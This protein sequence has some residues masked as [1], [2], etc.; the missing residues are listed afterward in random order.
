MLDT[1]SVEDKVYSEDKNLV[2]IKGIE[3]PKLK[4]CVFNTNTDEMVAASFMDV[5]TVEYQPETFKSYFNQESQNTL[6]MCYEGPLVIIRFDENGKTHFYNTKRHDCTGSFWGDKEEKFGEIFLKYGGQKFLD[7]V[8]KIPFIAHHFM[9]MTPSL[10]TTSR[11]DFRDN[12]GLVVYLGSVSLDGT[13]LN[14]SEISPETF[15]YHKITGNDFLPNKEEVNERILIPSRLTYEGAVHILENG[16][17]NYQ[18]S[19][20][21]NK[22][23][24]CGECVILRINNRKIIKFVPK[25]HEIRNFIAGTTPNIKNRLYTIL[26]LSKDLERYTELF[27]KAGCLEKECIEAIRQTPCYETTKNVETFLDRFDNYSETRITDRMNNIFLVCL[28]SCPLTKVN[29]YIDAWFSYLT[30]K[31]NVIKFIKEKNAKIRNGNYDECLS[32]FH[33]KALNRI[34]DIAKVSKEYAT[35][36]KNGHTYASKLEYSIKGM[37]RN[38]FGPSLYRIEKALSYL[39]QRQD[40]VSSKME[41]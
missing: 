39:K 3:N 34:K 21:L 41:S 25:C 2:L 6:G 4:G 10:L 15:Y 22:T 23:D 26:E 35:T 38:E 28:M 7:N 16:Y 40:S 13:I 11:V 32:Q 18:M 31:D 33:N 5:E 30:I 9:L 36:E 8:D 14:P 12:Q 20:K 27:P 24:F 19:G 29:L 1:I 17:H 37:V